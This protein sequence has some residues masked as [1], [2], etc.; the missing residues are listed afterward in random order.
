MDKEAEMFCWG[1]PVTPDSSWLPQ[2]LR[3]RSIL[4][5]P[6][7]EFES[8]G[9]FISLFYKDSIFYLMWA[10]AILY[11]KVKTTSPLLHDYNALILISS[12]APYN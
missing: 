3:E 7:T 8:S 5:T 11:S 4:G 6:V 10:R 2:M 9:V 12:S 1:T